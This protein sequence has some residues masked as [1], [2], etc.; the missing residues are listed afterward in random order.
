MKKPSLKILLFVLSVCLEIGSST[1]KR[2]L[3]T[4]YV[5]KSDLELPIF[6]S[7]HPKN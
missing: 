7:P 5:D 6:L 1:T 4:H 2:W 3:Q